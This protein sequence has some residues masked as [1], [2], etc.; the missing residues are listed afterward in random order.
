MLFKYH[1]NGVNHFYFIITK[2]EL[3]GKYFEI[4]HKSTF[5]IFF[6]IDV[7]MF[8]RRVLNTVI[9]LLS[10][11]CLACNDLLLLPD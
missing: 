6:S 10:E 4:L 8:V 1:K 7:I 5:S 11:S 2:T 3:N 9:E